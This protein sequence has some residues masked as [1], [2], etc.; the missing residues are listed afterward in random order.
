MGI[1]AEVYNNF[2]ML[3]SVVAILDLVRIRQYFLSVE[4]S[5]R[6]SALPAVPGRSSH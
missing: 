1:P 6:G 4:P 5:K 2:M 3:K